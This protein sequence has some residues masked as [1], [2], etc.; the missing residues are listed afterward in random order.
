MLQNFRF[1][2]GGTI[3][4]LLLLF[5]IYFA[6]NVENENYY[7]ETFESSQ[8]TK[9]EEISEIKVG[10]EKFETI[11]S[12]ENF[13]SIEK[14]EIQKG[15]IRFES[16]QKVE[17]TEKNQ[18]KIQVTTKL[19]TISTSPKSRPVSVTSNPKIMSTTTPENALTPET[20]TFQ[21]N[22]GTYDWI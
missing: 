18:P 2:F 11:H 16:N 9:K 6:E 7:G 15:T 13:Q 3:L 19:D 22:H 10:S 17:N 14:I 20:I 21:I 5:Y 1:L 4:A 12:E 8:R